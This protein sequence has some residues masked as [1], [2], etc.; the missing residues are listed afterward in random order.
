MKSIGLIRNKIVVKSDDQSNFNVWDLMRPQIEEIARVELE[1]KER[2]LRHCMEE[3]GLDL[4]TFVKNYVLEEHPMHM[5][6]IDHVWDGNVMKL[7][8]TQEYRIKRREEPDDQ[9][10]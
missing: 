2:Y 6:R 7:R 8:I 9:G 4:A 3:L 10:D 1:E 5:E